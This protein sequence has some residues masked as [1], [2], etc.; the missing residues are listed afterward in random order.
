VAQQWTSAHELIRKWRAPKEPAGPGIETTAPDGRR[1]LAAGDQ[2]AH[3]VRNCA[4][5]GKE[6][7]GESFVIAGS[8]RLSHGLPLDFSFD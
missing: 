5:T 8:R 7:F 6:Q 3:A 4:N 1:L 2:L